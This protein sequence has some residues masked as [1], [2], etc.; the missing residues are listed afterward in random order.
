MKQTSFIRAFIA[1]P[2][3]TGSITPSSRY[4]IEEMIKYID[5]D[6]TVVELGAGN[7]C[8]TRSIIKKGCQ[9]LYTYENNLNLR[10]ELKQSGILQKK[11]IKTNAFDIDTLHLSNSIDI[12]VSSL[13]LVNFSYEERNTLIFKINHILKFTGKFIMF[14]YKFDFPVQYEDIKKIG[15]TIVQK[16]IVWLNFPPAMVFILQKK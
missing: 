9:T 4:L 1:N 10:H 2:K 7:G 6:H 3:N 11:H 16:K 5:R 13:P 15:F 14:S 8:I 12:V